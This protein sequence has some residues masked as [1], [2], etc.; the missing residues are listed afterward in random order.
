[1]K[2][3]QTRGCS[4]GVQCLC[5]EPEGMETQVQALSCW[6]SVRAGREEVVFEMV[7]CHSQVFE[8][9]VKYPAVMLLGEPHPMLHQ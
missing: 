9:G 3:I 2:S 6:S 1:M 8:G 7:F 5:W 4:G